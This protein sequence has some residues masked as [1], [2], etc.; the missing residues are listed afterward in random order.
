MQGISSRR[1][2]CGQTAQSVETLF[3]Y[4]AGAATK[5]DHHRYSD[6]PVGKRF[7]KCVVNHFNRLLKPDRGRKARRYIMFQS[8]KTLPS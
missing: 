6:F 1:I 8:G 4:G 3:F 2:A 7:L 5:P